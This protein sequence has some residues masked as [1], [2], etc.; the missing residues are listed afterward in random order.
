M[1]YNSFCEG[2]VNLWNHISIVI[3]VFVKK[4]DQFQKEVVKMYLWVS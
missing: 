3:I 4:L 2:V 1:I